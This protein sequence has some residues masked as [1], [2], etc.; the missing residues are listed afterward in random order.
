VLIEKQ[1]IEWVVV[2]LIFYIVYA[3]PAYVCQM[4]DSETHTCQKW[5]NNRL[6]GYWKISLHLLVN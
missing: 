1:N 5:T 3:T 6:P 4:F 2:V